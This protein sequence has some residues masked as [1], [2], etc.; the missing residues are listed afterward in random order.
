MVIH[1]V[2]VIVCDPAPRPGKKTGIGPAFSGQD[3][4]MPSEL[5]K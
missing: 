5:V 1:L 2:S 4:S 3:G